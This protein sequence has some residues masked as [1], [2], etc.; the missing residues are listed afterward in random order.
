[1]KDGLKV[2]LALLPKQVLAM[3]STY[4][5]ALDPLTEVHTDLTCPACETQWQLL[6][7]IVTFLWAEI[8]MQAKR[9]LREVHILAHAYG[10]READILSMNPIRRQFYLEMVT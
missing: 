8:S 10:W 2:E 5:E 4:I 6:F 7:D 3:L 1:M 9:L